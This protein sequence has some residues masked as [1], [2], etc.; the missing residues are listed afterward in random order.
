MFGQDFPQGTLSLQNKTGDRLITHP[1][2]AE[3][4]LE[5]SPGQNE[6]LLLN[7]HLNLQALLI[8]AYQRLGHPM[9]E[10]QALNPVILECGLI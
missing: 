8:Q 2:Q 6:G 10:P 4:Y 3:G 9:I 1:S 5:G 7:P